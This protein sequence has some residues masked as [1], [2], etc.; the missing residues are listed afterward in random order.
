MADQVII[1]DDLYKNDSESMGIYLPEEEK[2]EKA[3]DNLEHK[4]MS[5]SY[6]IMDELLDW[7]DEQVRFYKSTDAIVI[8]DKM[9]NGQIARQVMVNKL[10]TSAL[11]NKCNELEHKFGSYKE[12]LQ[13]NKDD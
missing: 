2:D 5:S 6:P 9:D 7:F 4:L 11:E 3:P 13:G 8:D 12:S 1:D 10:V